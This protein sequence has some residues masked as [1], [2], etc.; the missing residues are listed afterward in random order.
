MG[1]HYPRTKKT[2]ALRG[3]LV[4][5]SKGTEGLKHTGAGV[6]TSIRTPTPVRA[7]LSGFENGHVWELSITLVLL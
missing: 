5:L 1:L 2:F 6:H 7:N 4:R 3:I